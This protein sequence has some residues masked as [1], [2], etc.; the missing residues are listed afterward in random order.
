MPKRNV[1][2][3]QH[4]TAVAYLSREKK[5]F[6]NMTKSVE[7]YY[8]VKSKR[9]ASS[10]GSQLLSNPHFTSYLETLAETMGIGIKVRLGMAAEVAK[11]LL[12]TRTITRTFV[13]DERG[14]LVLESRAE[15]ES[16]PSASARIRALRAID[17]ATG[18]DE[19][20]KRDD[21]EA[22][23]ELEKMYADALTPEILEEIES[24]ITDSQNPET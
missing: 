13:R 1:T 5:T 15:T 24:G 16:D 21:G 11:G 4:L 6:L 12:R 22:K 20:V 14:K 19:A 3:K 10:M 17:T 18:H 23:R 9:N 7:E 2:M 8:N